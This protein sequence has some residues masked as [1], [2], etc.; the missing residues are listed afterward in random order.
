MKKSI[1]SLA[2][3]TLLFVACKKEQDPFQ[4]SKQNIGLLTDSTQV[5]ELKAVLVNDSVVERLLDK[6]F[7]F[8]RTDIDVF[9]KAGNKLLTLTPKVLVDSTS[10]IETIKILDSRFKTDKGISTKSTF[11]DIEKNYKISSIQNT[12]KN[13]VVFVNEINAFFTIDKSQLPAELQFDTSKKIE[14]VQ[15]PGNA[16][17]KYFMIGW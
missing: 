4:I 11:A 6:E 12:L 16:K 5:K 1:F 15:I 13:I 3:I 17:I 9:D 7:S 10:T 14:A 2:I 8:N